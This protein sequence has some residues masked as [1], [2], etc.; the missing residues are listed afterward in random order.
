MVDKHITRLVKKAGQDAEFETIDDEAEV[1]KLAGRHAPLDVVAEFGVEAAR[2]AALDITTRLA[3]G[4]GYRRPARR[5]HPAGDALPD[6]HAGHELPDRWGLPDVDARRHRRHLR[7]AFPGYGEF[8]EDIE[9]YMPP[10]AAAASSCWPWR[11][12]ARA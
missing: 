2:D 12:S 7:L 6:H 11:P 9:R 3:I 4:A 1:I 8:A 5:R 10:T